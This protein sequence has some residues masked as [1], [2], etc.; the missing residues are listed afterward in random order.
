MVFKLGGEVGGTTE[1]VRIS[2][3]DPTK[4]EAA[5]HDLH[6]LSS[7]ARLHTALQ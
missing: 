2:F 6:G 4:L 5:P 7:P 3:S 1:G